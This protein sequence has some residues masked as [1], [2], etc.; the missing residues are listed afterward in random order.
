MSTPYFSTSLCGDAHQHDIHD[1][2]T[3]DQQTRLERYAVGVV[4]DRGF[5]RRHCCE[6]ARWRT[7]LLDLSYGHQA[8][9]LAPLGDLQRLFLAGKVLFGDFH[10]RLSAAQ[11]DV[12]QTHFDCDRNLHVAQACGAGLGTSDGRCDYYRSDQQPNWR[13]PRPGNC[14]RCCRRL[15]CRAESMPTRQA[16]ATAPVQL[17]RYPRLQRRSEAVGRGGEIV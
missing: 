11:A 10:P 13:L 14:C 2:D 7:R 4:F 8:R 1:A 12:G 9:L 3:A 15:R 16:K 5:L 6:S 17:S